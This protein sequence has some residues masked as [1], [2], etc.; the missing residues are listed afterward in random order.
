L[1]L[2]VEC[3]VEILNVMRA[4]PGDLH[5]S[6]GRVDVFD[7][8]PVPVRRRGGELGLSRVQPFVEDQGDRHRL[9]RC[10]GFPILGSF[11][12]KGGESRTRL[13]LRTVEGLGGILPPA[14]A[15]LTDETVQSSKWSLIAFLDCQRLRPDGRTNQKSSLTS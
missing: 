8:H 13:L 1:T 11:R 4:Q 7:G 6:D 10:R 9:G 5:R 3:G 12:D 2:G 15:V 14:I